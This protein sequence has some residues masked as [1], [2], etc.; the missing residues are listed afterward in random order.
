MLAELT[1]PVEG[2]YPELQQALQY[3]SAAQGHFSDGHYRLVAEGIRHCLNVLVGQPADEETD[4]DAV[5]TS[6]RQTA[7]SARGT[8]VGYAE[9]IEIIRQ[10]AKFASDLGAH[11]EAAETTRRDAQALLHIAAGLLYWFSTP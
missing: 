11:P 5:S 10:A 1:V 7:R 9:R 8:T 4:S 2:R 6:L 3:W